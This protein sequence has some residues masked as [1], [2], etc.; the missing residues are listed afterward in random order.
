MSS[1]DALK[2][3]AIFWNWFVQHEASILEAVRSRDQDWFRREMTPNVLA[4]LPEDH[5]GLRINWE[6]GPGHEKEWQFYL[7]PL[8]KPNL[9]ITRLAVSVAPQL[10][11]WEIFPAK[12]PRTLMKQE[13]RL[14]R[15][16]GSEDVFAFG[17]WHYIL[18]KHDNGVFSIDLIGALP[19]HADEVARKKATYLI[20]EGIRQFTEKL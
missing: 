17:D 2:Q 13:Y 14:G 15:D 20:V 9:A 7:S 19:E 5:V 3:I 12:L 1:N 8:I 6:I 18:M 11:R 4:L 16:D 10:S